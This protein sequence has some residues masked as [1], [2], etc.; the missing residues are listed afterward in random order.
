MGFCICGRKAENPDPQV[1]GGVGQDGPRRRG[2]QGA[3]TWEGR[4][5]TRQS[6]GSPRPPPTAPA[7]GRARH[8][9]PPGL[10]SVKATH[11]TTRPDLKTPG[12]GKAARPQEHCV[13]LCFCEVFRGQLCSSREQIR[14]CQGERG[15]E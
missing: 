11:H 10:C 1:R 13:R 9:F 4:S 6:P 15:G 12:S 5:E 7:G 3:G 8:D 14:G 2:R